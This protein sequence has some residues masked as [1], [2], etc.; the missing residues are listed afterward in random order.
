M[1]QPVSFRNAPAFRLKF[2]A[3]EILTIS[4]NHSL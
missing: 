1:I 3:D 2:Q 4:A